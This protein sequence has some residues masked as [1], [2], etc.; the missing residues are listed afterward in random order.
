[1]KGDE[2]GVG[3]FFEDIPVLAFV[4]AGVLSVAGTASWAAGELAMAET[5]EELERSASQ[6][7]TAVMARLRDLGQVPQIESVR[8]VDLSQPLLERDPRFS[9]MASV[10]CLHPVNEP[11]I[12][13]GE[14]GEEPETVGSG[15]GLMNVLCEAGVVGVMEVRVFVWEDQRR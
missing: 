15:R 12:V 11:L 14:P 6:L 3:G 4:L 13:V 5:S 7:L 8:A 9:C 2:D 10:W 1:M